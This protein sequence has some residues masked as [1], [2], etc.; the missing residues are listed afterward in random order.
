ML[1]VAG[2]LA[3]SSDPVRTPAD[4]VG[5]YG[6]LS[7]DGAPP[8]QTVRQTSGC[9]FLLTGG[10]LYLAPD[11]TFTLSLLEDAECVVAENSG[12]IANTW[13]G[14]YTLSGDQVVLSFII[15]GAPVDYSATVNEGL[16]VVAMGADYG[17]VAFDRP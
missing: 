3:C 12:N 9:R 6:L 13:T 14:N 16:I 15:D 5:D 10:S 7:V 4:V 17:Q 11:G 1:S 8:P 2:V